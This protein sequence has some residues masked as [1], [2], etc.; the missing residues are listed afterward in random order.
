MWTSFAF[1]VVLGI[2]LCLGALYS[3][4][5]LSEYRMREHLAELPGGRAEV[6]GRALVVTFRDSKE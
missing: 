3:R 5:R 1:G 6:G 2:T 4:L